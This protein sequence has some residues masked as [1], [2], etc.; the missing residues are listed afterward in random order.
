MDNNVYYNLTVDDVTLTNPLPHRKI[1]AGNRNFIFLRFKFNSSWDDR[2]KSVV[3]IKDGFKISPSPP[4]EENIC[5]I[6]D[7]CM[8][9]AGRLTVSVFGDN[10][11]QT[12]PVDIQIIESFYINR[13]PPPLPPKPDFIHV[14]SPAGE[15]SV[16]EIKESENGNLL[17]FSENQNK[18]VETGSGGSGE[19]GPPGPPGPEGPMGPQGPPGNEDDLSEIITILESMAW[20][21]IS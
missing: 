17:F 14:Q 11:L 13:K 21:D 3:F 6:P 12:N 18:W 2:E 5:Q 7:E 20:Q 4:V 8:K 19:P 9:K 16:P 10:R 1:P 15:N